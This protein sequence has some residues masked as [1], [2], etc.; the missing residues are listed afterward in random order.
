MRRRTLALTATLLACAA[1]VRAEEM[2]VDGIAAQVG[3]EIVLISEVMRMV[4]PNERKLRELG[5]PEQE[6]AKLRAEGLEAMIEQRLSEKVVRDL[7]L[8]ATDAEVD[9]TIESIARENGITLE[10]LKQ[11]VAR[12]EMSY[13]EYRRQIKSELERRKVMGAMVSSQIHVEEKEVEALYKERFESQ[14]E[15]GNQ[16]HVRQIL[17]PAGE[18]YGGTLAESCQL[19]RQIRARIDKGEAFEELARQYSAAAPAQGGDIGWLHEGMVADWMTE[20]IGPLEDGQ[21]SQ[22][23]ELS[24]GCTIVKLVERKEFTPIS[25]EEART[26]LYNELFDQRA[27]DAYRNWMEQLRERTFIERRGYFADAA[28]FVSPGD[29]GA[30][31][32]TA[33]P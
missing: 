25:Y 20:L 29:G 6:I 26:A 19:V 32:G 21:V 23:M 2:L 11:S 24:F 18:Q 22:V 10:H 5:A 17:V 12:Q 9:E 1:P 8:Y 13:E 3:T 14:P 16:V 15:G 28:R 4:A 30:P 7:E 33:R 27:S 31:A